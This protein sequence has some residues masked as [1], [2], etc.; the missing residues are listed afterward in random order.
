MEI[1]LVTMLNKSTVN[2]V[3][4]V[5]LKLLQTSLADWTQLIRTAFLNLL[6]MTKC[7]QI[8][9]LSIYIFKT[10]VW[11]RFNSAEEPSLSCLLVTKLL[12]PKQTYE[13]KILLLKYYGQKSQ[14]LEVKFPTFV[15]K[16]RHHSWF[17]KYSNQKNL[18]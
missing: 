11:I 16:G 15:F 4:Q 17:C 7:G 14:K 5:L 2:S 1:N 8:T 6:T 13:W 9:L 18:H 12:T 10:E 3:R